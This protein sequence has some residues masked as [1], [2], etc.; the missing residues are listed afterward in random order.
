MVFKYRIAG[1]LAIVLVGQQN[2]AKVNAQFVASA[3]EIMHQNVQVSG[4]IA[5]YPVEEAVLAGMNRPQSTHCFCFAASN[6]KLNQ[7]FVEGRVSSTADFLVWNKDGTSILVQVTAEGPGAEDRLASIFA[8][9]N[10]EKTGCSTHACS[11]FVPAQGLL[12]LEAHDEVK[13]VRPE[14][15]VTD[16]AGSFVSEAV[17]ALQVNLVPRVLTGAGITIGVI[18]DSFN[19]GPY[20]TDYAADIAAGDLPHGIEPLR[21]YFGSNPIPTDEGRAMMQLIHD[22]APDAVLKFHTGFYGQQSMADGI[23]KLAA[24]GCDIIVDDVSKF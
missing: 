5:R 3:T 7:D 22:I 8:D 19:T 13:F 14:M 16:Q 2:T 18:S 17:T 10:F 12:K 24:A 11:G 1:L 6:S 20:A 23:K 21:E 9:I 4:R 15:P